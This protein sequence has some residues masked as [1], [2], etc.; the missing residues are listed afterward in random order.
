MARKI[1]S[2]REDDPL[3]LLQ[4]PQ[5]GKKHS[6][7]MAF[8]CA[9]LELSMFMAQVTGAAIFTD[10]PI[11]WR[12]LHAATQ[13]QPNAA[14]WLPFTV[15][16]DQLLFTLAEVPYEIYRLRTSVKLASFRG[17][18]RTVSKLLIVPEGEIASQVEQL[19]NDT[20]LARLVAQDFWAKDCPAVFTRRL[21][22][23]IPM[24]GFAYAAVQR[25]VL[26]YE[27]EDALKTVPLALFIEVP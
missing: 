18:F 22:T 4:P 24:E 2:L 3:A 7:L 14:W 20:R 8:R 12:Q 26:T 21:R 1:K 9:P 15:L 6:Q 19:A 23:M 13:A 17:V 11:F 16:T 25:Q 27:H 5:P 10:L